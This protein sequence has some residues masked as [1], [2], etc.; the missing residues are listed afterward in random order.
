VA[1]KAN[2][3]AEQIVAKKANIPAEQMDLPVS[4]DAAGNPV[5]LREVVQQKAQ[6]L[7]L[8]ALTPEKKAELTCQRIEAQPTFEL[9]MLGAGVVTKER[10]I[11][12]VK[13]HT[14]VGRVLMEI[15]QRVIN[16]LLAAATVAPKKAAAS[17]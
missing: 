9:A 2:I 14:D 5:T 8:A 13:A 11:E 17:G 10:A 6:M 16:S 3:P 15:E 1:K 4:F 12:E 7:S